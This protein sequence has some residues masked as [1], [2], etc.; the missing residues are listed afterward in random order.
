MLSEESRIANVSGAVLT[1]GASSRMGQ[2]KARMMVGGVPSATRVVRVLESVVSEVL[3]VGG[4]PPDVASA[5]FV[6]DGEGPDSSLR[7]L[8]SA[9]AAA[10]APR[11]LVVATDMPLITADLLLLL[12]AHPEAEAVVPCVDDRPQPLCAL[13]DRAAA[14]ECATARLSAGDLALR[15]VLDGLET[16]FVTQSDLAKVD[17]RGLALTNVNTPDALQHVEEWLEQGG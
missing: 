1:G 3:V 14:L 9:L 2:D 13:Y 16:R 8:T 7:G 12:I 15:S 4:D 10:T 6:P 17:P 11:L 5:R